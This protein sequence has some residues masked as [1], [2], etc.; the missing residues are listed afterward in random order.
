[1]AVHLTG[2][3]RPGV[4]P[5]DVALAL[6][7]EVFA[8]GYVKNAILEFVGQGVHALPAEFRNGIDVMTT[9]T[10]CLSS[11]WETDEE[12]RRYYVRHG[13]PEAYAQLSPEEGAVYDRAVEINVSPKPCL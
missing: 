4:G 11:V 13:R 12:I 2:A 10:A 9:E 8:D 6:I 5:Q 3:P 7:G 1:M